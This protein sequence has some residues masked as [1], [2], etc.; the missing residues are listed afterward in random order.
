M[1]D[2]WAMHNPNEMKKPSAL[3]RIKA[4]EKV[5]AGGG[6]GAQGYEGPHFLLKAIKVW[7]E[8]ATK[9]NGA[10]YDGSPMCDDLPGLF[11]EIMAEQDIKGKE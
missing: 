8:I 11:E 2:P 5:I 10:T 9:L 4:I 1:G 6:Y 3:E 7:R